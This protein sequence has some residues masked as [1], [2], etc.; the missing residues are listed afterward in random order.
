MTRWL[1][2]AVSK[3]RRGTFSSYESR[4]RLYVNPIVGKVRLGALT[5]EHVEQV[6][7]YAR[8][9]G[10]SPSSIQLLRVIFSTPLNA[11]IK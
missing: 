3:N 10:L 7:A 11:A 4:I 9:R 5:R 2:Q 1:E 6:E 8:T